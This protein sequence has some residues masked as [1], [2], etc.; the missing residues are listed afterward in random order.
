MLTLSILN[1][2]ESCYLCQ[3]AC[4][5]PRYLGCQ[6]QHVAIAQARESLEKHVTWQV[7]ITWKDFLQGCLSRSFRH[8]GEDLVKCS[9]SKRRCCLPF[10]YETLIE[11]NGSRRDFCQRILTKGKLPTL[12]S[13][14]VSH[15]DKSCWQCQ[16]LAGWPSY[17]VRY[18]YCCSTSASK[19]V[20]LFSSNAETWTSTF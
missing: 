10:R 1:W 9:S 13:A 17:S 14:A 3:Q 11:T 19:F 8:F 18:F 5:M 7:L 16:S 4:D 2:F 20:L 15:V 6:H 12:A